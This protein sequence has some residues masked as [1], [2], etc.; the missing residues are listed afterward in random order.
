MAVQTRVVTV[1]GHQFGVAA[2][3]HNPPP[4]HHRDTPNLCGIIPLSFVVIVLSQDTPMSSDEFQRWM[5]QANED[6]NTA[7][8]LF[9][10]ERYG[11]AAFFFQQS[12]EKAI[13]AALY[14]S[15]ERPWGHSVAS[16]LDQLCV[17][18]GI[19]PSTAPQAEAQR[20]DEHYVR[21]RYPDARS[22]AELAYDEE[23]AQDALQD[24]QAL[25]H[26]VQKVTADA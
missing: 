6:I 7:Q 2:L 10:S 5:A 3:L 23:T 20:L 18:L 1:R 22:D 12:A 24:A 8:I 13:K 16:L 25:L 21:P 11:P 26:F 17:T 4:L 19:K 14:R 9:D 15:G